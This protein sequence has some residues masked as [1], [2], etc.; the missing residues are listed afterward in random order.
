MRGYS[1]ASEVASYLESRMSHLTEEKVLQA[2]SYQ[3]DKDRLEVELR[4]NLIV[5]LIEKREKAE[6]D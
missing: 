3:S 5:R 4:K 2:L 1:Q 6:I